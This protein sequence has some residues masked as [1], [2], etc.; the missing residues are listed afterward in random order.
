[1]HILTTHDLRNAIRQRYTQWGC[2]PVYILLQ[3]GE[4]LC[5]DCAR[6]EYRALSTALRDRYRNDWRPVLAEVL[7]ENP[8]NT[9]TCAH[10]SAVLEPA[11]PDDPQ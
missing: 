6:S 9:C 11:Y 8:G 1:M 2:Y 3:D 10:C 7:W 5:H 4:W